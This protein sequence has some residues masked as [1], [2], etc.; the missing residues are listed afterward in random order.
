[1]SLGLT[2][3]KRR[4]ASVKSTQKITK[5]MEMVATVKVKRFRDA[6][7]QAKDYYLGLREIMAK[8]FA[9]DKEEHKTHYSQENEGD[10][11]TLYILL[12]SD[13]G[14]CAAYNVNLFRYVKEHVNPEKDILV[15]IGAKGTT[16]YRNTGEFKHF[17]DEYSDFASPLQPRLINQAC[18]KIKDAFNQKKV[19]KVVLISTKYVNSLSYIPEETTLL[20]FQYEDTP[21]PE[22]AWCPYLVEPS[23]RESLHILLPQYLG[24]TLYFKAIES[25][26]SEQVSRRTAMDNANDNADELLD[27]LTIEYNKA[28]QG[29][30]TQEITE[31]VSGSVNA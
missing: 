6:F 17:H 12:T 25:S 22:E 7:D 27:K 31:V 26:L 16:H 21:L 5:A 24:A 11:P 14:L 9:Y 23:P 3:T 4:I 29:A 1:M 8:L 10:L 18:Q 30:I 19:K 28:R 20:P 15:T 13:L 2:K